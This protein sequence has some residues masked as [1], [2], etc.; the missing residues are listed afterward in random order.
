[1]AVYIAIVRSE[2]DVGYTASFPDFPGL[3]VAA[4]RLELLFAEARQKIVTSIEHLLE[5]NQ[6]VEV[7]KSADAI[8]RDGALMLA[9]IE[10]PD[11]IR[12]AHIDL[13]VPVLALVRIHRVSHRHELTPSQR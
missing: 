3:A 4:S 6:P 2:S 8:D 7:P 13:A 5:A 10:L 12:T 1:M 11:D 9:A